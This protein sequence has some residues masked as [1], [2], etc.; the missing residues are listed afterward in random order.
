MRE[1]ATQWRMSLP[2]FLVSAVFFLWSLG[3]SSA[4]A[5]SME[6]GL[7]GAWKVSSSPTQQK[8]SFLYYWGFVAEKGEGGLREYDSYKTTSLKDRYVWKVRTVGDVVIL[9]VLYPTNASSTSRVAYSYE[10]RIEGKMIMLSARNARGGLTGEHLYLTR[11]RSAAAERRISFA[12]S[13][14]EI[15][16]VCAEQSRKEKKVLLLPITCKISLAKGAY[17]LVTQERDGSFV[18]GVAGKIAT[19]LPSNLRGVSATTSSI[20]YTRPFFARG[21]YTLEDVTFDGYADIRIQ[22]SRDVYNASF[23]YYAFNPKTETFSLLIDKVVNPTFDAKSKTISYFNKA[24]GVG[25]EYELGVYRFDGTGYNLTHTESRTKT[26]SSTYLRIVRELI[27]GVLK[28]TKEEM[29][30]SHS[31]N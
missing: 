24:G 15:D 13:P 18:F 19:T 30:N 14:K 23:A 8:D 11:A 21:V 4:H 10:I 25:S 17:A 26:G 5:A 12:L 29:V 6:E 7:L 27:G 20:E 1:Q 3:V 16:R 9:D 22:L 28:V 2:F 31:D